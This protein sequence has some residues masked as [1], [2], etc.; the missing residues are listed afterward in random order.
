MNIMLECCSHAFP[1]HQRWLTIAIASGQ[2]PDIIIDAHH[3][4]EYLKYTGT[5]KLLSQSGHERDDRS[6]SAVSFCL[7]IFSCVDAHLPPLLDGQEL[8]QEDHDDAWLGSTPP[9]R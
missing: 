9:S 6:L 4:I 8:T 5:R 3:I 1:L 2:V 7:I